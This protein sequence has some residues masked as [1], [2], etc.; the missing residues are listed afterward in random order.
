MAELN[1]EAR[2][3]GWAPPESRTVGG[4]EP[5]RPVPGAVGPPRFG[6]PPRVGPPPSNWAAPPPPGP[7]PRLSTG[8][9][10]ASPRVP[11]PQ[12]LPQHTSGA[13]T[14]PVRYGPPPVRY[15]PSGPH[16]T[17]AWGGAVRP[18]VFVVTPSARSSAR[19]TYRE[20]LPVRGKRVAAGIGAGALWMLLTAV[21][22]GGA[23][24]YAWVTIVAGLLGWA[25]AVL[26]ARFG[27]RGVAAGVAIACGTG[28]AV[29]GLVVALKLAGGTWLLW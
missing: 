18:P 5:T 7:P 29:A 20:P 15:A 23:R 4:P 13:P 27:D 26:L 12:H 19:P 28:V 2:D 21:Q 1:D 6:P 17:G 25:V 22:T 14:Q 24:G 8:A 16:R 9:M 3:E 11:L 10:P